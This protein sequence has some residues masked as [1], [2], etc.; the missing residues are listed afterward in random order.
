MD[1]RPSVE[2]RHLVLILFFLILTL[3][4]LGC[5]GEDQPA[6]SADLVLLG[7]AVYTVDPIGSQASAI[8]VTDGRIAFVGADQ[9]ARSWIGPQTEVLELSGRMV[10]PGFQDAHVHPLY[11]GVEQGDCD[12]NQT[13]S[14]DEVLTEI[15]ECVSRRP[16]ATWIRGGGY[17]LT[18]FPE[19]NPTAAMLDEI[20]S[21]RP[22]YLSSA[23]GHSAW[24]NSTALEL[25]GITAATPDPEAGR[26][27]RDLDSGEPTGTLRET[28]M[29]LVAELLPPHTP[30][31]LEAGLRRALEMAASF[32]ITALQDADADE[33]T[34]ATY[35]E[36]ARRGELT[37]R[38]SLS[39]Q[40]NPDRGLEQVAE[41]V[42]LRD[43]FDSEALRVNTVK[44][45]ADGVLEAQTAAVLEPYVGLGDYT[46]EPNFSPEA[47]TELIVALD[48]EGFQIHVHAIGD[49]AI[50]MSL[51]ALEQAR[52]VNGVRDSRHHLAHIQL[53][54]P[55]DIPRFRELDVIAN[56]QPLWA[57]ADEYIT[58]LTV[59][60]LGAERSRW[61]YPIRS[62]VDSGATVVFGSD[63]SVSSMNPL[64]GIQVGIT[65]QSPD[66]PP[67]PVWIPEERVDLRTMIAGYTIA[68]A[69]VNFLD[70]ETGSIEVGKA[71]DLVV[72]ERDLFSIP[73]AE[74]GE[75][76]VLLTLLAGEVIYQSG[77]I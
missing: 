40:T 15:A 7:A 59:P 68:A 36:L 8:V 62:L 67:T 34:V 35:A 49:G 31:E 22:L 5:G 50:R 77:E 53:F 3:G 47:L 6:R 74:I 4:F 76:K 18:Y 23:D 20:E 29:K 33:T 69:K 61:L 30:E 65:R 73:P 12:L 1:K 41:L 38:V 25:A 9:E 44:L 14:A 32:G 37:A 21:E 48:A 56:F 60:F 72:L 28:A 24:V 55:E 63:W 26:I 19:G 43:R 75:T 10:L 11:G 45:F 70:R 13:L 57:Y 54:D 46:G 58:D 52:S 39:L 2:Q 66:D 16:D 17:Q 71:A 51:D 64:L 42:A 27:E